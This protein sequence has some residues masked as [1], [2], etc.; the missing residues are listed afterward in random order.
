MTGPDAIAIML[1]LNPLSSGKVRAIEKLCSG[2]TLLCRSLNL[3]LTEW[4]QKTF[5]PQQFYFADMQKVPRKIIQ[6][7]RQRRINSAD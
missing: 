3:K 2:Q 1:I 6:T 7:T 4:D 5:D